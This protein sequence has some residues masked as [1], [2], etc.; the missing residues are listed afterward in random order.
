[1]RERGGY[2]TETHDSHTV[3]VQYRDTRLT[4]LHI[5]KIVP[6]VKRMAKAAPLTKPRPQP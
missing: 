2:S 1:M 5:P 4:H 3:S 6:I